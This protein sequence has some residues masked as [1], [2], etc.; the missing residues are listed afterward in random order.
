MDEP[1]ILR[2]LITQ[3]VRFCP[4]CGQEMEKAQAKYTT[5]IPQPDDGVTI[6]E[7]IENFKTCREGHGSTSISE[8]LPEIIVEFEL[9]QEFLRGE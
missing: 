5:R 1:H 9:S 2:E 4:I 8:S 7:K 6:I 3:L